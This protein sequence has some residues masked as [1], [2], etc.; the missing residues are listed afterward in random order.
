MKC[1]NCG[2]ENQNGEPYC[3][4][5]GASLQSQQ[6]NPWHQDP[7]N[8]YYNSP[9]PQEIA[10]AES[11]SVASLVMGIIS[12]VTSF[13]FAGIILAPLAISRGKQARLVLDD[14]NHNFWIA[15]GGVITGTI[16]LVLSI[17]G[18]IFW[19]IFFVTL[20]VFL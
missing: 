7:N 11:K 5:C 18:I 1:Y 20:A 4:S 2:F 16:G 3:A 10:D 17:L 8:Q 12:M 9:P 13:F 6:Y 19:I 14:R 15:L